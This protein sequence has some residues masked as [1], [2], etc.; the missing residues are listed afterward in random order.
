MTMGALLAIVLLG[1]G[2]LALRSGGRGS[3]L[4]AR[5]LPGFE[6]GL[7][8]GDVRENNLGYESGRLT[9]EPAGGATTVQVG[10]EPG[11]SFDDQMVGNPVREP[12]VVPGSAATRS[13]T[14]RT[15]SLTS[16]TTQIVCGARRVAITTAGEERGVESLHRQ[17]AESFRCRVDPA[18]EAA[19]EDVPVVFDLGAGWSRL[20]GTSSQIQLTD[21][22]HLAIAQSIAGVDLEGSPG[23]W[24]Q[25]TQAFPG[26]HLG[27]RQ[28][29]HWPLEMDR[30]GRRATG[31]AQLR[32]CP[33]RRLTVLLMWLTLGG[34][35]DQGL[36]ALRRARCRSQNEPPQVWP[37]QKPPP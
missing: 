1:A 17:I 19:M 20:P 27:D 12:V 26:V 28:G 10:W 24:F 7:P 4:K 9:V 37:V 14:V 34:G 2:W 30:D 13:S 29:D 11:G 22:T 18:R 32:T 6:V 3:P 16:W 36:P 15:G 33:E 21:G 35:P 31:W 5:A 25:S 23:R 8:A